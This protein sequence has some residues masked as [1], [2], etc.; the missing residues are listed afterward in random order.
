MNRLTSMRSFME[1]QS[2][3]ELQTQLLYMHAP[4]IIFEAS[5][6]HWN[7]FWHCFQDAEELSKERAYME[8]LMIENLM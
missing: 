5:R 7:P 4:V 1:V 2:I 3:A 8:V 6:R